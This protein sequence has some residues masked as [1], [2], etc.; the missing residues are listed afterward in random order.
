V[1]VKYNLERCKKDIVT[2]PV[3]LPVIFVDS[4]SVV[5]YENK[6]VDLYLN[7]YPLQ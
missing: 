4:N 1:P 6:L 5:I 2:V 7:Y 3:L